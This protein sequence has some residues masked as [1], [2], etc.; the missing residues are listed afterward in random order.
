VDGYEALFSV[1]VLTELTVEGLKSL[2]STQPPVMEKFAVGKMVYGYDW[3]L[4]LLVHNAVALPDE[5]N[6]YTVTFPEEQGSLRMTC[7]RVSAEG[8]DTLIILHSDQIPADFSFAR[9]QRVEIS[10]GSTSG[11]YIP[12]TALHTVNGVEGVYIFHEST[13][14]FRRI[15]VIY[16]GDGYCIAEEQPEGDED[17]LSINDLLITEGKNLYDG[18][19]Y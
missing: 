3:Y 15:H 7:Q 8:N 17:Y 12:D 11:Y 16:R 5:G 1:D 14:R 13:V 18:K 4:A 10:L 6:T 9:R 2:S 19:V